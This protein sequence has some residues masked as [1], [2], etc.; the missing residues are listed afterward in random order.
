M[1]PEN[2]HPLVSVI[3]PAYNA[4]ATIAEAVESVCR[5]SISDIELI[6][7]DDCS[8]DRTCQIVKQLAAEDPRIRFYPGS[9]NCGVAA[10]RNK[11]IDLSTGA[12]VALLDSDDTWEPRKLES[13]L[14]RM[15]TTGA[16]VCYT[17]YAIVDHALQKIRRDYIV[18]PSI[19]YYGLLKENVI[20][21]STVLI[22]AKVLKAHKF[23]TDFYHED[24][25][26]WL[27]LLKEGHKAVGET[28]VLTN[29]R[30]QENS[31]SYD[32]GKS[33]RNRWK[34]YRKTEKLSLAGSV[35]Y[36]FHYAAAALKK[37]KPHNLD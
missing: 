20:G 11:G 6:I 23:R 37:Y 15:Q 33:L 26:L 10:V 19:D 7:L 32:K 29:W 30:Y 4:E 22:E 1:A 17:S 21:C 34:I 28:K 36:L 27:E 12:Y 13:Q 9:E 31:R 14:A 35:Y 3:M 25:V 5:Q 2:T 8:S 18:P 24:Y 16:A